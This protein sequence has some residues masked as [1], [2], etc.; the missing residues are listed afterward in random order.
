MTPGKDKSKN[1][2]S[3]GNNLNQFAWIKA[4][5]YAKIRNN[6]HPPLGAEASLK[7]KSVE[8]RLTLDSN[9][10]ISQVKLMTS[11]GHK[12][13]DQSVLT[14]VKTLREKITAP[15]ETMDFIIEFHLNF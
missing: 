11:S 6:W 5:L 13:M 15:P 3:S 14:A 4:D 7:S 10:Q 2:S 1:T 9:G 12:G 8:I